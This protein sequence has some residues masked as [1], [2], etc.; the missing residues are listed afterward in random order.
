MQLIFE[1]AC[2]CYHLTR[3][4]VNQIDCDKLGNPFSL[5]QR[6]LH[7]MVINAITAVVLAQ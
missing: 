1:L 3:I 6:V 4:V 7:L 5:E 2:I